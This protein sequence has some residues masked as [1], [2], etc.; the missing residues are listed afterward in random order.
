MSGDEETVFD[1]LWAMVRE[2]F[3]F[4]DQILGYIVPLRIIR[5]E[6][7]LA[8]LDYRPTL[9]M[10]FAV[11][12]FLF[13]GGGFV[14]YLL[15]FGMEDLFVI[16]VIGLLA[17]VCA[18]VLFTGTLREIYYF[19]RTTGSYT[20]IRQFVHR[21]EVIEG[22]AG[23]FK[24]TYV[25][26]VTDDESESESYFVVLQQEGMFLTG[27]TEQTLRQNV[28]I[29]NSYD[30]ELRIAEAIRAFIPSGK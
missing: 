17:A 5:R 22:D 7:T 27:E 11:A 12:G 14:L 20:F 6:D 29:F 24:G 15:Y 23:Q 8:I 4:I 30:R 16:S 28:P 9:L 18:G 3:R 26:T 19:D 13:F 1:R 2:K 10:F 25:K 21:R